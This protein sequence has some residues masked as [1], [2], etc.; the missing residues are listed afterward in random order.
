MRSTARSPLAREIGTSSRMVLASLVI[1][2]CLA[3]AKDAAAA[4]TKEACITAFDDAQRARRN[5]QLGAARA[6]LLTC[7]Q[8]E[9]PAIVRAD[10]AGVLRQVEQAQPTIV[11]KASDAKGNDLTDVTV[12][13]NGEKLASSLDGRAVAVDP[14]KLSLVFERPPWKPVTVDVV[15]AEAEKSRIVRATLGPPALPE[16]RAPREEAPPPKRGALGYAVPVALA[17]AGAGAL[18]FAGITRLSLGEQADDL[19]ARCSPDCSQAER[20]RMSSDL[21]LTNV[22]LGAGIGA[23]VLAAATWFVLA[24]KSPSPRAQTTFGAPLTW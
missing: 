23:L 20:D 18:A 4:P 17:A 3:S 2:A 15:V 5:G 22:M 7:S 14:G 11:L 12:E 8:Q 13:L 16:S 6:E 9:C 21:V 24:P 1:A 10:C 19:R